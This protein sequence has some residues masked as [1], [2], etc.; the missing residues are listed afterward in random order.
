LQSRLKTLKSAAAA[1]GLK[2]TRQRLE[3]FREIASRGDHPNAEAVFQEVR[4]R[5][6]AVSLDTVYRTLWTLTDLGMIGTLGPRRDSQRFDGNLNRHHHFIC[7]R[8]GQ[9]RDFMSVELD[10]LALPRAA[11]AFGKII[12]SHVEV[13]GICAE[14]AKGAEAGSVSSGATGRKA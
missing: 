11:K 8:C 13:H 14:C 1:A 10:A 4:L 7:V 3:I 6:P 12:E 2:L 9:A 5:L